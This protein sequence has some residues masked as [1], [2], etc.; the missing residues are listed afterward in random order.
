MQMENQDKLKKIGIKIR[1]F[2][3]KFQTAIVP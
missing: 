3:V 2:R 1:Q